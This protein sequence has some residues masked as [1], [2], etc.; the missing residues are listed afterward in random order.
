MARAD[1]ILTP[2]LRLVPFEERHLSAAYVAWL[3]DKD[4]LQYSENRHRT[5]DLAS[6]R[7]YWSSMQAGPGF[8]WAVERASD[9]RHIGN[10]TASVDAANGV[11]DLGI[12]IGDRAAWGQ[13]YGSEAWTA[14]LRNL[15]G[16]MGM[17]K[18]EG[19]AMAANAAMMAIFRR[20]GMR[21][22]GAR[23]RHFM[24]DGRPVDMALFGL[25]AA[26]MVLVSADNPHQAG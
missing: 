1:R 12:L 4:A 5:H 25:C 21:P 17:R 7:A 3:N 13:G 26:D 23:P 10:V 6:C 9:N 18:V 15:L 8:F 11:A 24:I 19:G 20:S 2:R 14:A 22:E 16:P